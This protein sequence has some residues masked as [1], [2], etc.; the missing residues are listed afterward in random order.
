[1]LLLIQIIFQTLIAIVVSDKHEGWLLHK[2]DLKLHPHARCLDGTPG[3][4]WFYPGSGSGLD[5]FII[6]HQGGGWCNQAMDC[7]SRAKLSKSQTGS[8]KLW[9]NSPNCESS[10]HLKDLRSQP[11]HAD[12]GS[13]G[14]FSFSPEM[15]PIM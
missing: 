4:Y 10:S 13:N 6:H 7:M 3:A 5:K 1:M 9:L 14:V 8:S 15:N 12:G 2:I 11:C